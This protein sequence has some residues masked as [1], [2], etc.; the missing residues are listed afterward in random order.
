MFPAGVRKGRL[1]GQGPS[2][3]SGFLKDLQEAVRLDGKMCTAN[4]TGRA[5]IEVSRGEKGVEFVIAAITNKATEL[6]SYLRGVAAKQLDRDSGIL[7]NR[8]KQIEE[9]VKAKQ[10][11]SKDKSLGIAD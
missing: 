10:I 4:L 6:V 2:T 7:R 1:C 8:T 11:K 5:T 3:G 9:P